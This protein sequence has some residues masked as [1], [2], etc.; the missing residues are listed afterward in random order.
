MV[1]HPSEVEKYGIEVEN[2]EYKWKI[3]NISRK[4]NN[5]NNNKYS[6]FFP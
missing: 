6:I 5:T 2:M 3:W 4:I 1:T